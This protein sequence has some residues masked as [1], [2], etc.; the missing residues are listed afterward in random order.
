MV[1]SETKIYGIPNILLGLDYISISSGGTVIIYDDLPE[2]LS[3]QAIKILIHNIERKKLGI[4]ARKSM[5]QYN[6][7][8]LIY[9]WIRLIFSIFYD[10]DY[11]K[12]LIFENIKKFENDS[13]II[14][15]NQIKLLKIREKKFINITI[16]N[17]IN[18]TYMQS[19]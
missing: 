3:K 12:N 19:I 7:K 1:L 6:N 5:K 8:L 13:K 18:F 14:L 4:D 9:K 10:D 17:F 11:H 16:N 15:K 2:S